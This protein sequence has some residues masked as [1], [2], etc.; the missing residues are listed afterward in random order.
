MFG[1]KPSLLKS[2]RTYVW[3]YI[4]I[5]IYVYIYIYIY[6]ASQTRP[7]GM[8]FGAKPIQGLLFMGGGS[9]VNVSAGSEGST[10]PHIEYMF[11]YLLTD[12]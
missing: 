7:A 9:L 11:A 8:G 4:Y 5:Y 2:G 10:R 1:A 3:C 6:I 12:M